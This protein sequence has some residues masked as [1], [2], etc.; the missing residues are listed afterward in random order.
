MIILENEDTH[1]IKISDQ[2]SRKVKHGNNL[3]DMASQ[4]GELERIRSKVV[5]KE[6]SRNR[7]FG[8][9]SL[10]QCLPVFCRF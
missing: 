2:L 5:D 3:G 6:E 7:N 9:G 1:F 10:E 8:E 4:G